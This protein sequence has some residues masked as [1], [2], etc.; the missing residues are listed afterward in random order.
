MS[1]RS[2]LLFLSVVGI[3]LEASVLQAN[4]PPLIMPDDALIL[5]TGSTNTTGYLV[6]VSPKGSAQI[7]IRTMHSGGDNFAVAALPQS[8]VKKLFHDL[9][10]AMPLTKMHTRRGMR[11]TSFGTATYITYKG[12]RSPDLTFGGDARANA[13][14]ADIDAI[15]RTLHLSNA[16]RRPL[17]R[18]LILPSQK[19]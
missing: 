10:A 16:L 12:Q 2:S 15:L 8:Q 13:L 14:K 19:R 6:Y 17:L 1:T 3:L 4:A 11:S 5:N 18:P 7:Y 9:T